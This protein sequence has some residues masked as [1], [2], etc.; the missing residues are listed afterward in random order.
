MRL[1]PYGASF[2]EDLVTGHATIDHVPGSLRHDPALDVDLDLEYLP[3]RYVPYNGVSVVPSWLRE[4]PDRP[5]VALTLGTSG[6][7][8][9]VRQRGTGMSVRDLL[10]ALADVNAEIV[11]TVPDADLGATPANVR[12]AGF[13]PLHV[14]A[15]TCR[16][17]IHHGGFGS[18]STALLS[19]V[20]QLVLPNAFDL[21]LRA[22][23]LARQGAGLTMDRAEVTPAAVR[24]RLVRLLAEP[25]FHDNA[26]RLRAEAC[27]LPA[28][29][30]LVPTLETLAGRVSTMAGP[31]AG[32]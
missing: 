3:V 23:Y 15:P 7:T 8:T 4:P 2:S 6:I 17:V 24:D 16:A 9:T 31:P 19:G 26:R 18:Y 29:A 5:R 22:G 1:R 20:P 12:V 25:T 32:R 27:A 13:V 11:A 10:D 28:P 21:S 30:D 14:L